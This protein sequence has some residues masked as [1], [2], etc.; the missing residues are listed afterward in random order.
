[1]SRCGQ[2]PP[3]LADGR[4][5]RPYR[6]PS[7]VGARLVATRPDALKSGPHTTGAGR[8]A[9]IDRIAGNAKPEQSFHRH[10]RLPDAHRT[11]SRRQCL[12]RALWTTPLPSRIVAWSGASRSCARVADSSRTHPRTAS[13]GSERFESC[14]TKCTKVLLI[15]PTRKGSRPRHGTGRRQLP[16]F[17][18]GRHDH[19][20]SP[21]C[22]CAPR[23]QRTGRGD[24]PNATTAY[25]SILLARKDR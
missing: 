22:G 10:L 20:P 12:E 24:A 6:R 18:F 1:V 5:R 25:H 11:T 23:R 2:L 17:P 15:E 16:A 19:L 9:A 8:K 13:R 21:S 3:A 7:S 4:Q 14:P